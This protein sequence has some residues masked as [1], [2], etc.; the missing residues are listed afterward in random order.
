MVEE[1]AG[2]VEH[3]GLATGAE[4]GVD[5]EQAFF[6]ERGGQQQLAQIVSEDADG[7]DVGTLFGEQTGLG[8]HGGHQ[9]AL[10]AVFHGLGD[11]LA[12]SVSATDWRLNHLLFGDYYCARSVNLIAGIE[13]LYLEHPEELKARS[14]RAIDALFRGLSDG[15]RVSDL[16]GAARTA[17]RRCC[18]NCLV[19]GGGGPVGVALLYFFKQLGWRCTVVD[20]HRP[21]HMAVH[22]RW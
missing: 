19:L 9:Q 1:F 11:V 14:A 12:K 17:A 6:A 21:Q 2:A 8:F 15:P 22:E 18:M 5:G 10:A 13:P 3:D 7:C 4:A 20:P 16:A